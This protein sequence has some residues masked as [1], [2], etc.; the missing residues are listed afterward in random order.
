[1]KHCDMALLVQ[2]VC[3]VIMLCHHHV[4]IMCSVYNLYV[5]HMYEE[6]TYDKNIYTLNRT[7]DGYLILNIQVAIFFEIIL[8]QDF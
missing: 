6:D 2:I 1:M 3:N 7:G 5:A 8:L 4:N